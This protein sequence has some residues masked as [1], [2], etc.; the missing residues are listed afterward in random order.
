MIAKRGKFFKKYIAK[1]GTQLYF[2]Q[3]QNLLHLIELGC[4]MQNKQDASGKIILD[5]IL[6]LVKEIFSDLNRKMYRKK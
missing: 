6:N 1:E 2:L 5:R 3:C 4:L